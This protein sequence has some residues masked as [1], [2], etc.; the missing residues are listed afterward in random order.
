MNSQKSTGPRTTQGKAASRYNALKHG[1]FA[2]TQIMFDE[3]AEDLAEL[4][5]EYHEHH[6]PADPEQR[7]L[8]DTL[9]NNEWRLRRLRRVE[10]EL[11]QSASNVFLEKH[12]SPSPLLGRRLRHRPLPNF[13]R[14]QRIVVTACASAPITAPSNNLKVEQALSPA[15]PA[16]PPQECRT[17]PASR[18]CLDPHPAT[19]T[20]QTHFRENGFVWARSA[21]PR[22]LASGPPL[23]ATPQTPM[24]TIAFAKSRAD[25]ERDCKLT[26]R[27]LRLQRSLRE[28][29][30]LPPPAAPSAESVTRVLEIAPFTLAAKPSEVT[31]AARKEYARIMQAEGLAFV[32]LHWLMMSPP[33]LHVTTPDAE[34]RRRGWQHVRDLI[35][36]CADL[37]PEGEG[38][39]KSVMVFGSPASSVVPPA[40]CRALEATRRHMVDGLASVRACRL[41]EFAVS[42]RFCSKRCR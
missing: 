27:H 8:V 21:K 22:R 40:A 15:N 39:S 16:P 30:P 9:V 2:T 24:E 3:K 37:S 6:N 12:R 25:D 17:R 35:D 28:N 29:G 14:L 20:I 13:E 42:L 11:W 32:G 4:A 36:L 38:A 41:P 7:F 34:T 1:I 10:A 31:A 26:F 33:E 23:P 19:R 5:A 18:F